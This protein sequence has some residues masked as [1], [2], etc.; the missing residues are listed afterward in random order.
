MNKPIIVASAAAVLIASVVICARIENEG[1]SGNVRDPRPKISRHDYERMSTI[2][3]AVNAGKLPV[4]ALEAA[5][6]LLAASPRLLTE[7]RAAEAR[8]AGYKPAP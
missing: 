8:E 1:E 6:P 5:L 2:L 3:S 7:E 4:S